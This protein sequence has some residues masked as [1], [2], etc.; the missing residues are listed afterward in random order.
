MWPESRQGES[1]HHHQPRAALLELCHSVVLAR[2]EVVVTLVD[3]AVGVTLAVV[4][5]AD[6][7]VVVAQHDA[8]RAAREA[9]RVELLTLVRLQVLALDAAVAGTAERAVE[10]VVVLSAVGRVVE[11]V[12]LGG[13]KGI[14]AGA[15]DEAGLVVA[16]CETSGRVFD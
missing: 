12:E 3:G 15:A 1:A 10:L 8:A 11:Y 6:L 5:P 16:A 7:V 2:P 9:A 4:A 14:A 13:G